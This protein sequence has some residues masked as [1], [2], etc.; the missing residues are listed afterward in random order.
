[1]KTRVFLAKLIYNTAYWLDGITAGVNGY[2]Y[3]RDTTAPDSP[4]KHIYGHDGRI[5]ESQYKN[6]YSG[7]GGFA[8]L[9][10]KCPLF[11]IGKQVS[12]GYYWNK[13]RI[14]VL[15]TFSYNGEL[16]S[17]PKTMYGFRAL[18]C[19]LTMIISRKR[20]TPYYVTKIKIRLV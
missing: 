5:T 1:M 15:I 10:T 20:Y 19:V 13:T 14:R 4:H 8:R 7:M 9:K 3:S 6:H 16:F 11:K 18:F 17:K 2:S 12:S